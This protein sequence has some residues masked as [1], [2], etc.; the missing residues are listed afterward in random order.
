MQIKLLMYCVICMC[1][2]IYIYIY[3]HI[4]ILA[5]IQ[6]CGPSGSIFQTLTFTLVF[7]Q[8]ASADGKESGEAPAVILP[9]RLCSVIR[10]PRPPSSARAKRGMEKE[11]NLK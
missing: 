1:V 5:L 2:Y 4:H 10:R 7:S 8:V 9:V 11:G 3:I 6:P